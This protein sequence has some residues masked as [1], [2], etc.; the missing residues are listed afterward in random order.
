MENPLQ[1][2]G[3]WVNEL[4][5]LPRPENEEDKFLGGLKYLSQKQVRGV[6]KIVIEEAR[7][8]RKFGLYINDELLEKEEGLMRFH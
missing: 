5:P 2:L 1:V 3:N 8:S 4:K 7:K 6:I